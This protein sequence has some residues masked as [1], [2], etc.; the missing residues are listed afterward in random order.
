VV[1]RLNESDLLPI[2]H[3]FDGVICGD[4]AF[5]DK[6]LKAATKLKV[7]CKW[8]TG[9]DSIDQ[10]SAKKLSIKVCNTPDAFT[11]PV[12]DTTL[13]FIL[14]FA[15][16]ITRLDRDMKKGLWLKTPSITLRE[17]TL[18]IIGLGNIGK[19]VAKRASSF[20]MNILACD[21]IKP[22][23]SFLTQHGIRMT[24]LAPLLEQ[25]DYISLH[26]DLN[27][28]SQHLINAKHLQLVKPSVYI[29]NT[30]RGPIIDEAA[31][32]EALEA[33]Q[34]QGVGLDVFE[35]EPLPNN[36]PLRSWDGC[37][38]SPHNSN[39]SPARWKVVHESTVKQL[40]DALK[41][42]VKST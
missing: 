4:D 38:I 23:P 9:I 2:I 13:G 10:V 24:K 27:T 11:D 21:P 33:K 25:S 7:I 39:S 20:G 5:S 18:G 34:I 32:I 35:H 19:A 15:R 29:I 28:T 40:I 3:D 17:C 26:C 8:G 16:G 37:F 6:V 36:S 12:A 22:S 1:E 42:K 41:S 14:N 30:A 31:L